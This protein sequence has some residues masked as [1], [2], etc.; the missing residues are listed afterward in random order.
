M[1]RHSTR[2]GGTRRGLRPSAAG[3]A[4]PDD[5]LAHATA[6]FPE[7]RRW[8][9]HCDAA[10]G[11]SRDGRPGRL[12]GTCAHCRRPFDLTPTLAPGTVLAG[13]WR[14]TG[15]LARGGDW[16]HTA[17]GAG[18]ESVVL[19]RRGDG[20]A[21][22]P[23]LLLGHDHPAL[24]RLRDVVEHDGAVHLVLDPVTGEPVRGPRDPDA[25]A[26]V[27][28]GIVPAVAHLHRLRLLHADLKPGNVLDT[29]DG[30]VLLDLGSVRRLDDRH[31]PVWGTEGF[32]APEI[33]PGGAGPSVASDVFALGRTLAVLLGRPVRPQ[34]APPSDH[35]T[36]ALDPVIA[37]A[38]AADPGLRHP[39]V[40]TLAADLRAASHRGRSGRPVRCG[41]GGTADRE[42]VH[43]DDSRRDHR[44]RDD[45]DSPARVPAPRG[46]FPT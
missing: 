2:A 22:T 23:A 26:A 34:L 41:V 6:L 28:L 15:L 46:A 39:D 20:D 4:V 11:R 36:T 7:S 27:V 9:P 13:R 10:V 18:G 40:E 1:D 43:Q 35:P 30:P 8:C 29:P 17:A 16:L 42:A 31:S 12:R 37:R 44:R 3:P 32:L 25:A 21:T 19:A 5:V 24:V 14:V 33:A 45:P 38:T